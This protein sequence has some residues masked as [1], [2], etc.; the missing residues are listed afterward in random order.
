MI[1]RDVPFLRFAVYASTGRP[2]RV[3][4]RNRTRGISISPVSHRYAG[5]WRSRVNSFNSSIE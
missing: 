1:G 5:E 4:T 2:I 3:G